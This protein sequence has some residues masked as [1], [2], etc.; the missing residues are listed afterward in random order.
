MA[1]IPKDGWACN[2]FSAE[3]RKNLTDDC[4]VKLIE[5][6]W[7]RSRTPEDIG[8]RA[9]FSAML[10]RHAMKTLEHEFAHGGSYEHLNL[11]LEKG[12]VQFKRV[13]GMSLLAH[14]RQDILEDYPQAASSIKQAVMIMAKGVELM[15][16][17]VDYAYRDDFMW[18][19]SP[20][21][22]DVSSAR[23]MAA[24]IYATYQERVA[25]EKRI[26]DGYPYTDACQYVERIHAMSANI[27][28][29]SIEVDGEDRPRTLVR[30]RRLRQTVA[31]LPVPVEE[32]I[33]PE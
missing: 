8:E 24:H 9:K 20:G 22:G 27:R 33:E 25:D 7:C 29:Y 21:N 14:T 17:R 15:R 31:P 12:V 32:Q 16:H 2:P 26:A 18:V 5:D 30:R 10:F 11:Q 28:L 23:C 6:S 1:E 4:V 13:L 3:I 19:A